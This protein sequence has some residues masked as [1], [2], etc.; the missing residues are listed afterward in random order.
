MEFIQ[1]NSHLV[2][3]YIA[4]LLTNEERREVVNKLQALPPNQT[5]NGQEG[6]CVMGKCQ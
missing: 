1:A 5:V 6:A 4:G 3:E 2:S